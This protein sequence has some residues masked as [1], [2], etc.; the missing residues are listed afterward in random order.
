MKN[1]EE[2]PQRI[3]LDSSILQTLQDY[4][5]FL[6]DNEPVAEADRIH[7][8]PRGAAKLK[9]LRLIM[10]I[11]ERAPFQFALSRNSFVEIRRKRDYKYLQWAYEVQDY[12]RVCFEESS[13]YRVN[14]AAITAIES[15]SFDY[16][17]VGDKALLRDAIALGCDAFLTMENRLPKNAGHIERTLLLRV[18]S[19]IEMWEYI[20]PWAA[21]FL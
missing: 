3:F 16:L 13:V 1:F 8:D 5:G 4:G 17:G 18:L 20:E 10:R 11:S 2:I 21:L 15:K 19:P 9:S 14:Q 7:R 12:W 6:Y